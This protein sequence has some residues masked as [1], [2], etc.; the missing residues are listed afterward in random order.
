MIDEERVALNA[1]K[2]VH[3]REYMKNPRKRRNPIG[4]GG[5]TAISGLVF[6]G[7]VAAVIWFSAKVNQGG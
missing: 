3:K 5:E 6:I 7:V 2:R 4:Q 1:S